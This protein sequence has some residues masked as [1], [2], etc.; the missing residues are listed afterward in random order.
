LFGC[1]TLGPERL[2]MNDERIGGSV[3]SKIR[4]IDHR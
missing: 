1:G 2:D 3:N 4:G